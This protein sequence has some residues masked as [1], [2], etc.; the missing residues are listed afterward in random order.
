MDPQAFMPPSA[1]HSC[2]DAALFPNYFGQ[3]CYYYCSSV[4]ADHQAHEHVCDRRSQHLPVMF[5]KPLQCDWLEQVH[6]G[7]STDHGLHTG[8]HQRWISAEIHSTP[9]SPRSVR[10]TGHQ[11]PD[12]WRRRVWMHG[13]SRSRWTS[14]DSFDGRTNTYKQPDYRYT[15]AIL[16]NI[17]VIK[18]CCPIWTCCSDCARNT[19]N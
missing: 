6:T 3:T 7:Q 1:W 11:C 5:H 16:I 12:Q 10:L 15:Y 8:T 9:C 2:R 17:N 4:G 14:E 19:K 18:L 13:Q